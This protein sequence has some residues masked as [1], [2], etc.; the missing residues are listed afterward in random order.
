MGLKT[1][2]AQVFNAGVESG[3]IRYTTYPAAEVAVVDGA[4]GAWSQLWANA[5]GPVVPYWVMGFTFNV[6]TGLVVAEHSILVSF[7]WGGADGPA[8]AA[9]NVL[10]NGWHIA[11]TAVAAALGP[12][13][14]PAVMLPRPIRVPAN[15]RM[16]VQILDHPV[17]GV[18]FT[19]FRIITAIAVGS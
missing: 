1:E 6:A 5:A 10:V 18:A 13:F 12:V 16:A 9:T 7:G 3:N 17:A 15:E 2:V 8:V 11:F 19:S 14:L 4:P